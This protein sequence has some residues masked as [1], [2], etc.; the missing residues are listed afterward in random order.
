MYGKHQVSTQLHPHHYMILSDCSTSINSQIM[1]LRLLH[2]YATLSSFSVNPTHPSHLPQ[3]TTALLQFSIIPTH[4][5]CLLQHATPL[6]WFSDNPTHSIILHNMQLP[7]PAHPSTK[8]TAI[9]HHNM[10]LPSPGLTNMLAYERSFFA[11]YLVHVIYLIT[12]W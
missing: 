3:H 10:Q 11:L 1:L 2:R 6:P 9:I 12:T 5:S 4:P 7:L 8:P